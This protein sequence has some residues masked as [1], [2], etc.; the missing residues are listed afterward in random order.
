MDSRR[1][2]PNYFCHFVANKPL[3][4]IVQMAERFDVIDIA[5][6]VQRP[7]ARVFVNDTIDTRVPQFRPANRFQWKV[8]NI[9]EPSVNY[10]AVRDDGNNFSG[11]ASG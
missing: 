8:E 11:V 2:N 1:L 5:P 3:L 6:S 4:I 7:A 10:S 9:S